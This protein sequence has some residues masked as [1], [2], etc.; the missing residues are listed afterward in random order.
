MERKTEGA[1]VVALIVVA[2]LV[3]GSRKSKA[4]GAVPMGLTGVKVDKVHSWVGSMKDWA[5][6]RFGAALN[7]VRAHW[8]DDLDDAVA[9]DVALS[10]LTHWAIETGDGAGEFNWNVG[11]INAVG[12]QKYFLILDIDGTT[13]AE[14]AFDS[15]TD[16]VNAYVQ[17]LASPRY[18][19]AAKK[20]ASSPA[21][22]DWF[23][24][25][26]KCGWFDPTTAKHPS[27]WD[28]AAANFAKHRA[29]L[30]QYAT[31]GA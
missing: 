12:D 24:T 11:N 28:Q 8:A 31:Q 1:G 23:V 21:E 2:A 30:S 25:L 19:P 14:R 4:K 16:G 13:H 9:R 3:L 5:T 18:A 6:S 22:P 29:L 20:L 17:L 26:G 27:T 7:A 10:M 15:L